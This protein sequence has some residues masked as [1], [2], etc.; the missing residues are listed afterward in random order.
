MHLMKKLW[1]TL[2]AKIHNNAYLLSILIGLFT[3]VIVLT[4]VIVNVVWI[5]G[6]VRGRSMQPNFY[7]GD[8]VFAAPNADIHRGDI[9]IIDPPGSVENKPFI[10]RVIGLPGDTITSKNDV[11]YINGHAINEPYLDPYKA[12]LKSGQLLTPDFSLQKSFGTKKVPRHSYFV[13]GDNRH[14][15]VD[16]RVFGFVSHDRVIGVVKM[17]FWPLNRITFY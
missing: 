2:K 7:N 12:K 13:L 10:K 17:R 8:R 6:E 4:Y 5:N 1:I 15:S 9:I 11:T 14:Q 16:S 3:T